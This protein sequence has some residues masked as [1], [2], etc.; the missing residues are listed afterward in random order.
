[1]QAPAPFWCLCLAVALYPNP[2]RCLQS[3]GLPK[4][5][6]SWAAHRILHLWDLRRLFLHMLNGGGVLQG[7]LKVM[8]CVIEPLKGSNKSG[9]QLCPPSD[10]CR[11]MCSL[12]YN[13]SCE[14]H[15]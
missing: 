6:D 7:D 2:Q 8:I 5:A 12:M 13:L 9:G 11:S 14:M 4:R 15:L 3:G 10:I 1:M